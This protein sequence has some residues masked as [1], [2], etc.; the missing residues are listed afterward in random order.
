MCNG[1]TDQ[2][3]AEHRQRR[4]DVTGKAG[5]CILQCRLIDRDR[6]TKRA[7]LAVRTRNPDEPLE[8]DE[9]AAFRAGQRVM[10]D[11]TVR[12]PVIRK[13]KRHV[14]QRHRADRLTRRVIDDLPVQSTVGDHEALV[15]RTLGP[16]QT[17]RRIEGQS[18][19]ERV[20]VACQLGVD[21][22][23]DI[24]GEERDQKCC[25]QREREPDRERRKKQKAAA[26]GGKPPHSAMTR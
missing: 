2:E 1:R 8:H 16:V 23:A 25:R 7:L 11:G 15:D 5:T 22:F 10:M 14:E 12:M 20:H 21:P 26:N 6:D 19:G 9:R 18:P 4:Q 24:A 17:A 13:R 3:Q